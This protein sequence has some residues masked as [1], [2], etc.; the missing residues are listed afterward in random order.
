MN[1][2]FKRNL[3]CVFCV[4][5]ALLYA[6]ILYLFYRK[7][8]P[9]G[10]L[11]INLLYSLLLGAALIAMAR[12]GEYREIPPLSWDL[13]CASCVASLSLLRQYLRLSANPLIVLALCL[14]GMCACW[15][16]LWG[17]KCV[18]HL[19]MRR[20][21][22]AGGSDR[23]ASGWRAGLC[24]CLCTLAVLLMMWSLS[25]PYH[26]SPDTR[27]Q[28]AQIHGEFPYNNVHSF[29]HTLLLKLLLDIVDNYGFVIIVYILML[30][31][32][33]GLFAAY[34][35]RRGAPLELL[36]PV[37]VGCACCK[38]VLDPTFAPW[39][40]LPYSFCTGMVTLLAMRWVDEPDSFRD[41]GIW[42]CA[43]LGLSLAGCLLMRQN[44]IV[45]LLILGAYFLVALLRRRMFRGALAGV[46]A[47]V[48]AL[49]SVNGFAYR[50][51]DV[52]TS[53]ENGFPYQVFASGIAA[54]VH[55]ADTT[56]DELERIDE[57]LSVDWL[58]G[59]YA[60]LDRHASLIWDHDDWYEQNEDPALAVYNNRFVTE[61]GRKHDEVVKLYFE[62]LPRHFSVCAQDVLINT[63][64][65]WGHRRVG[66]IFYDN[67]SLLIALF[68]A[69][70]LRRRHKRGALLVCAPVLLNV[71]SI[72]IST[73]TNET[74]YL[75]PTSLLFP[76]LLFYALTDTCGRNA[77]ALL[78]EEA[79]TLTAVRQQPY[80]AGMER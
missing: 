58:R 27:Y 43:A 50:A 79:D 73:I 11:F 25:F 51:M 39:K 26:A 33:Y 13:G 28:W 71:V 68:L 32:L 38:F 5:V 72:A 7:I 53:R 55:D 1:R 70:R 54:V 10:T 36:A 6:F 64:M 67:I 62:L 69:Y 16:F 49:T 74:R 59:H 4:G 8:L 2:S 75:L 18:L 46:T 12:R 15:P 63:H 80:Q 45:I 56:Q 23:P 37:F 60:I 44:G 76:A 41:R 57:V 14:L 24:V 30:A 19:C 47:A 65:I 20:M 34:F 35:A 9:H 48:I 78:S 29:G 21:T 17:L 66:S 22:S 61:L 40:D 42:R 52:Q 3:R 77:S 31:A